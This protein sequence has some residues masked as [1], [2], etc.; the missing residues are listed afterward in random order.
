[1]LLLLLI[2]LQAISGLFNTDDVL[3]SGPLY[4]AASG[5]FRDAMGQLHDIA[6]NLL[7]GL[8]ALHISVVAYHQFKLNENLIQAMVKG[9]APGKEGR[10]APLSIWRAVAIAA[11]VAAGLW[12]GLSQAPQPVSIW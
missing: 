4:Y 11:L 12:F 10:V 7:L 8:V 1:M 5:E 9:R 3:F 6:F 2:L